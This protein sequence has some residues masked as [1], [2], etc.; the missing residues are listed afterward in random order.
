LIPMQKNW[1]LIKQN[2]ILGKKQHFFDV[3]VN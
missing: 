2:E 3:F 1:T